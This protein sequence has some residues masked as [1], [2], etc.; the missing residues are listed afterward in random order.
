FIEQNTIIYVFNLINEWEIIIEVPREKE[1]GDFS[2]NM[3]M[4]MAREARM[5]PAKIAAA[6]INNI[7]MDGTYIKKVEKAG[8]GFINFYLEKD[9]L[10]QA[11][12]AIMA[13]REN[14]GKL[15]IGKGRKVM[16]EF[17]SANPT[18]PLHMG[19]ARGGAL[20]DCIAR[21]LE[22][23]G[24]DVTREFYINDTGAQVE[25]FGASLEARYI[26][27]LKGEDAVEFPE[28]GYH[29]EDVIEHAR[30]YI[31]IHGDKLLGI[32]S[33]ERRK[34]L[35][36]Y[37]LGKNL[38]SIR[39]D[40]EKYG[41]KFDV[42]FSEKT[43]YESGE[44]DETMEYLE[45]NG[46]TYEKDG[47]V[48]IKTS[49]FGTDKDEVLIRSNGIPTYFASDIAYH[50]NKFL[51]RKFDRVINLLGADHHGHSSR[52]KAAM[53]ALGVGPD[54]L[55]IIV[56]QLVRLYRNGEIARMSKRTGKSIT[57]ADILDEV[58]KDAA[59]FFFSMQASGSHLDFDLDMAV[60]QSDENP[61]YYV[62][63]AHARI[64]SMLRVLEAEGV[65]VP[66][67]G[68]VDL[69]LLKTEAELELIRKLAEYPEE[70]G[71]AAR[72]LEPSRLT[73]YA[74][75]LAALFHG[76]Y[77]SCRVK[78]KEESLVKARLALVDCTRTVIRDILNLL[79]I[80]APEKM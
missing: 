24:Y 68:Q 2:T 51:K 65:K 36:E 41:I 19:N 12:Q 54:K 6:I 14:Y 50:R 58:G 80:N 10:Y 27:L 42:W 31:K 61:V 48:W 44:F 26:Q 40:L 32:P 70:I 13:E 38:E 5:P 3:A 30:N 18:G 76:F 7:E 57:L 52:M 39:N 21:I 77:N 11:L 23:V 4:Q 34:M 75:E 1:F 15:D 35:A 67:P 53:E 56:F 9:W 29:G 72:T 28:D 37:A 62:Q 33:G 59:R 20:G 17:V 78:G 74:I 43:L 73:R 69:A 79:C 16:V 49:Q 8:P 47:A 22:A 46:L 66:A 71:I 45:Q 25:K 64:C 55:D 63:Y 60:K